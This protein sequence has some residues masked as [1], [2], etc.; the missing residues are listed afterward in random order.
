MQLTL[1]P[2]RATDGSVCGFV[3]V[4]RDLSV[5]I[6]RRNR[7]VLSER[8]AS[9]GTLSAGVAHEFN[10]A[11]GFVL[12]SWKTAIFVVEVDDIA[13]AQKLI[14]KAGFKTLDDEALCSVEPFHYVKY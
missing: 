11:Y 14:D 13:K 12:D 8:L 3:E 7:A 6:D 4:S 5:E 1:T 10:N 9:L 2:L